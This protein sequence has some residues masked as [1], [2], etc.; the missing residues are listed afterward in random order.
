MEEHV[1]EQRKV[2]HV[3]TYTRYARN[4]RAT[5]RLG[6]GWRPCPH[7][8]P[9]RLHSTPVHTLASILLDGIVGDCD[10]PDGSAHARCTPWWGGA[11]F[12]LPFFGQSARRGSGVSK[13]CFAAS[14]A[15]DACCMHLHIGRPVHMRQPSG[16]CSKISFITPFCS[17]DRPFELLFRAYSAGSSLDWNSSKTELVMLRQ[18][19]CDVLWERCY[20]SCNTLLNQEFCYI[21]VSC[22]ELLIC[23]GYCVFHC[24]QFHFFPK[25]DSWAGCCPKLL[26]LQKRKGQADVACSPVRFFSIFLL[27]RMRKQAFSFSWNKELIVPRKYLYSWWGP[28]LN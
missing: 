21:E 25:R 23:V 13:V 14:I 27:Y 2:I 26:L 20:R 3:T 7:R 17:R 24:C 10:G 28:S 9:L 16:N 22:I 6:L 15:S 8:A 18:K 11:N 19:L 4:G 12:F 1:S 5:G